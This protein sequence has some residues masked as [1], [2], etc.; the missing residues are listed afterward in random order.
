MPAFWIGIAM[1]GYD[2][3]G[4]ALCVVARL[5]GPTGAHIWN[6]YSRYIWPMVPDVVAYDIY[7]ACWH[8][9]AIA[10]IVL[11]HFTPAVRQSDLFTT[12]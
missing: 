11:G 3:T 1:V 6:T 8:G 7:W 4:H 2:A 12:P 10:L 9:L 5:T